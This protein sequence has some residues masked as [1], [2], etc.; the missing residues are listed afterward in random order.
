MCRRRSN[1]AASITRRSVRWW[2]CAIVR[3]TR[4]D[5]FRDTLRHSLKPTN[6]NMLGSH[7]EETYVS[8]AP[9]TDSKNDRFKRWPFAKRVAETIASRTD[10]SS[11]VVAIYGAWGDGKTSV[12]NF[13]SQELATRA[14]I[15]TV[16]FNPWRFGDESAVLRHFFAELARVVGASLT[17][18]SEDF[19][20]ALE[21]YGKFLD[22]AGLGLERWQPRQAPSCLLW[23]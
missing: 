9:V 14:D 16:K 19:G 17:S 15:L 8:D 23:I 3:A 10:P 13:I 7:G 20:A 21:K 2:S 22:F 1:C 4:P 18:K 5:R 6:I 11:L 12:L